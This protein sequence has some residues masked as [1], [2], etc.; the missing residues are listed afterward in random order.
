[1][2]HP[3]DCVCACR[4]QQCTKH[5]MGVWVSGWNVVCCVAGDEAVVL[6]IVCRN[7]LDSVIKNRFVGGLVSMPADLVVN[8]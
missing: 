7:W 1:M 3:L 6:F 2:S 8:L 4:T 5:Y